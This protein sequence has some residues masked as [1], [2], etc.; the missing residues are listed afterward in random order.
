MRGKNRC[1]KSVTELIKMHKKPQILPNKIHRKFKSWTE[2]QKPEVRLR[3]TTNFG[4]PALSFTP[5]L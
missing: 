1:L 4:G 3:Y 5:S 2:I